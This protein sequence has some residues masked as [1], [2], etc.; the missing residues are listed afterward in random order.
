MVSSEMQATTGKIGWKVA[1][2]S[3]NVASVRYR[4]L[5]PVLAL[6]DSGKECRV[7]ADY[8]TRNLDDLSV[9]V[10][11][12]GLVPSDLELAREAHARGIP[13]VLDL[14]DCIFVENY[15]GDYYSVPPADTFL[16]MARLASA[17]VLS[18]DALAEEVRKQ[19]GDH[20]RMFVIPDGVDSCELQAKAQAVLQK[21]IELARRAD[22]QRT[23]KLQPVIVTAPEYT[24]W[25]K[26]R[27]KVSRKYKKLLNAV[28]TEG[29][30]SIATKH[31]RK[32]GKIAAKAFVRKTEKPIV[33]DSAHA[34]QAITATTHPPAD[35]MVSCQAKRI[36]WF[37]NHGAPY[38]KFGML[39]LL[40]IRESLERMASEM[41][42]KLVVISDNQDKYVK[43]IKP[44]KIKS[45]YIPWSPTAVEQEFARASVVVIPNP[46]ET[47]S[48]CKSANRAVLA[49]KHG[50]PVVATATPALRPLASCIVLDDFENGLRT[51]LTDPD[52][53]N[54]DVQTGKELI[55]E[56]YGQAQTC[57][58]WTQVIRHANSDNKWADSR[59]HRR[60]A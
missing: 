4:A 24:G 46:L 7:F 55:E 17:I 47:F 31:I 41:D 60:S 29:V 26:I 23:T 25:T 57:F 11:V 50:V 49:L 37:G 8:D 58:E 32:C 43:N 3:L 1:K 15:G 35:A 28:R 30:T 51:Y 6:Q 16:A 33:K 42:V 56:L 10:I 45:E 5:L 14:C 20:P 53:A 52:R 44:L 54:L 38:A 39:D 19:I 27:K 36:L 12:K 21:S 9:L 13:I 59:L 48:I 2:L 40:E 34:P 22:S 18:T